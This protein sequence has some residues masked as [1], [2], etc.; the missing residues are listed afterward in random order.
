VGLFALVLVSST[1]S[2][3]T[4]SPVTG[5]GDN[6]GNL[7]AFEHV[8]A[9]LPTHPGLVVLLHGCGQNAD[10]VDDESGW[11]ALADARG[12]VLL[13]PQQS[14]SNNSSTCFNW[15][16]PDDVDS[17]HGELASIL[18]MVEAEK[19]AHDVDSTRVFVAGL[20]AGAA[21][22][23][24]LLAQAPDVFAA[25][26][27]YAGLP[28]GCASSL[29]EAF[30]CQSNPPT[31]T[32]AEW[33]HDVTGTSTRT[34]WPRVMVWHGVDDLVVSPHNSDAL[35]LQWTGVHALAETPDATSTTGALTSSQWHAGGVVV[36][37][38]DVVGGMGHG[39]AI[40]PA[41]SCGVPAPFVVDVGVCA[42]EKS[43]QFFGLVQSAP[44]P[45]GTTGTSGTSGTT[46]GATHGGCTQAKPTDL[47]LGALALAFL[48]AL[49]RRRRQRR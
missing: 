13:L 1:A 30:A 37:E 43:A 38:S 6:P 17:T 3:Q 10:S 34:T 12:F 25:G 19:S 5:F 45:G 21:M 27:L 9:T 39:I 36:V 18:Q 35:V 28:V 33:A 2:A 31:H 8:P 22:G 40:D 26:A 48:C 20:S 44:N 15:F 24:A 14:A 41:H 4:L 42:A 23:A 49:S 32:Q 47:G 29:N 7:T 46:P 16:L 11:V